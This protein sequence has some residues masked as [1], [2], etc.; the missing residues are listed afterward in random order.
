MILGNWTMQQGVNPQQL[1]DWFDRMFIDGHQWVMAANVIGMSQYADGGRMSTKPY[2]SGGAYI[3]KMTDFCKSCVFKPE[4]RVGPTACPFTAGYWKF[5]NQH[6]ARFVKNPRMSRA[7]YG[8][9]RLSDRDQ[10]MA[11]NSNQS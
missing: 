2:A 4:V 1:V 7:V 11:E 10:L 9:N 6:Q 8:L 5:I 3:N